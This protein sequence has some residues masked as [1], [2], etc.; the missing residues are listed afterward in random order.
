MQPIQAQSELADPALPAA[1]AH[2][3]RRLGFYLM[4]LY[5]VSFLDRAN[6]SF[7]K[8]ALQTSVGIS[9]RTY[10]LAAGLFFVSYSL[11]G[12]PS[13]LILHRIGAKIWISFLMIGWG[14]AS[15]ATMFV[16]GSVSFYLLR[17]VLGVLEGG[18]FPG[19]VLYLTYWFPNRVRGSILGLFY[20]GVPISL[21]LGGPLSGFLLDMRPWFA[22][23]SWQTMFL[24]EGFLAVVLGIS[25]FWVLENKP[26]GARWL[27]PD[28]KRALTGWLAREEVDRRSTGPSHLLR[29]FRDLR[30]LRFW[31]IYMLIQMS[32]YGAIFYLPSEISRLLHR[33]TGFVVGLVSAIPWICALAAVYFIPLSA[34]RR[35]THRIAEAMTLFAAGCACF[36][37]PAAGPVP[38]LAALSILVSGVIAVQPLFWTFPTSYL[39]DTAAAGGIAFIGTGNLGG[40]LAPTLKVWADETFHSPHAGFY[41]LAGLTVFNAFLIATLKQ[42]KP[43]GSASAP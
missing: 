37:F 3:R 22:L 18:F 40:F 16:Q 14:F 17:I 29:I 7:A 31:L 6:I 39:A 28:E 5:V 15:M 20:L 38:A 9:E 41:A 21:I 36:I 2:V 13:N 25:A 34:D 11:C 43:A 4:L 35:R 24:I 12:F 27:P 8:Q 23:Q 42:P 33:N 30:V 10:A 19:V 1:I 26:A 32:T